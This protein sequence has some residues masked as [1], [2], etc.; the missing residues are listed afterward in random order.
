VPDSQSAPLIAALA[1]AVFLAGLT[2]GVAGLGFSQLMAAGFAL[3]INPKAA[4][5]LLAIM[6]PVMS[7]LQLVKHRREVASLRRRASLLMAGLLGVPLGVLLLT[8]LPSRVI[9]LLLGIF[10]LL[11]VATSL[12]RVPLRLGAK[13]DRLVAPLVGLIAGICSGTLAVSGPVLGAYLLALDVS[14]ATFAFTVSVMFVSMGLLRL[15]GLVLAG[16]LTP[17]LPLGLGLLPPAIIGQQLG[18]WLQGRVSRK[19]FQRVA[20]ALMFL[21]GLG[22]LQR[23]LQ[24]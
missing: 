15:G 22:L 2:G 9:A 5:V 1:V 6:T 8:V 3:M 10:T 20:L 19:A 13:H 23:G 11:F 12:R 21:A 16:E 18:F 4:V 17:W 24:L 14:A 7:G